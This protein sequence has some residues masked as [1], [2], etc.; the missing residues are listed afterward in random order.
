ML[1]LETA[2]ININDF[3]IS[4]S[5]PPGKKVLG[6]GLLTSKKYHELL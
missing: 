5:Q 2:V 3:M 4:S 1:S 6:K